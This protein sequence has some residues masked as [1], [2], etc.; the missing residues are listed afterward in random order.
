MTDC[1]CG[2]VCF[3]CQ[4]DYVPDQVPPTKGQ[5]AA[6]VAAAAQEYSVF[7]AE[8]VGRCRSARAVKARRMVIDHLRAHWPWLPLATIGYY[9]GGRHHSTILWAL[10][11]GRRAR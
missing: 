5:V 11:N 10:R 9:L 3:G 6:I 4:P 8:V 7:P 2:D 1:V